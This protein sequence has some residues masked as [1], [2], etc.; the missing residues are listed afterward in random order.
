MKVK[1]VADVTTEGLLYCGLELPG[2]KME[3]IQNTQAKGNRY[4]SCVLKFPASCLLNAANPEQRFAKLGTKKYWK[5]WSQ[6]ILVDSKDR[7]GDKWRILSK[8]N[9]KSPDYFSIHRADYVDMK[10][11]EWE[12]RECDKSTCEGWTHQ[13]FIFCE[14]QL[15]EK[16]KLK[17]EFRS[18][19]FCPESWNCID[20][21]IS[22]DLKGR[23]LQ[24]VSATRVNKDNESDGKFEW[25][26]FCEKLKDEY[27]YNECNRD[28]AIRM[29]AQ[30]VPI[31][32]QEILKAMQ[33]KLSI[34]EKDDF[35]DITDWWENKPGFYYKDWTLL[36][37]VEWY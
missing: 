8:D 19:V 7:N 4:G 30:S 37:P 1:T 12:Y 14:D 18:H 13:A 34:F 6:M 17:V 23:K 31:D 26:T 25:F 3:E 22:N 16:K 36:T 2:S 15:L 9:S 35:K 11:F 33:S 29:F 32:K 21:N 28:I 5:E 10:N 27:E 24:K 20:C